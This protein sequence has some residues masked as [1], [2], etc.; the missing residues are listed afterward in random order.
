MQSINLH[1]KLDTAT[2]N[3]CFKYD[4]ANTRGKQSGLPFNPPQKTGKKVR[5]D[6]SSPTTCLN[7]NQLL[8][9]IVYFQKH[10]HR[11]LITVVMGDVK[12]FF[13]S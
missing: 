12:N 13:L 1:A 4:L 9:G 3:L 11:A 6:L 7:V 2:S 10:N 8:P 5:Q